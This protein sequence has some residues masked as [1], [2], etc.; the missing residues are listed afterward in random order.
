MKA[1]GN[2]SRRRR[3][4]TTQYDDNKIYFEGKVVETFPAAV[5]GVEVLRKNGLPP[6]FIKA[7]TKTALKVRRIMIIKGD[8]VRVE[9]NPEEMA[10]EEGSL[11]GTIVE[12]LRQ[13]QT[14]IPKKI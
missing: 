1:K 6:M 9:V 7:S 3:Q 10:T 2:S 14:D 5:F 11:K 4:R 13:Q 12:R 8:M